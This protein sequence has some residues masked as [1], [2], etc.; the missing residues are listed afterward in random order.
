MASNL[1]KKHD[2]D[3]TKEFFKHLD[4]NM[5]TYYKVDSP[6]GLYPDPIEPCAYPF[7]V[8]MKKLKTHIKKIKVEDTPWDEIIC[9][10]KNFFIKD[11]I[12][13]FYRFHSVLQFDP[14]TFDPYRVFVIRH[15]YGFVTNEKNMK[16]YTIYG[17]LMW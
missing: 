13:I 14:I 12:P 17:K 15:H 8:Y 5:I 4:A 2:D 6:S 9:E 3:L 10:I 1:I 7:T 16:Y 11:T